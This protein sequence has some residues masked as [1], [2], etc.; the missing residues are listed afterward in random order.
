MYINQR[1]T[2]LCLCTVI[3]DIIYLRG[4]KTMED[5]LHR[6]RD[7]TIDSHLK[8]HLNCGMLCGNYIYIYIPALRYLSL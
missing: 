2:W 1:N 4:V 6:M 7:G 3:V 5:L 8:R